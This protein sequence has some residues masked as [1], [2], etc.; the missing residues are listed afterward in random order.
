MRWSILGANSFSGNHFANFI[1]S[2][3]DK[4]QRIGRPKLDLNRN[5]ETICTLIE[6]FEADYV[7]NFISNSL[8]AA[9]WINPPEWFKTN[10]MNTVALIDRLRGLPLKRFVHVSTPEV[11]GSGTHRE[12]SGYA[13]TTPY[14]VSR[15][16]AEMQMVAHWKA[17]GFPVVMTRSANVYGEGQ[18]NKIIPLAMECK[19]RGTVLK[20]DGGG[21]SI[22]SFIHINDVCTATRLIAEKG[23][24]GEAYN[25]ATRSVISIRALVEKIGCKWEESPERMAKDHIYDLQTEKIRALGWTDTISLDEGLEE[26]CISKQSA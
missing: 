20:L 5:L 3:G 22:R 8:V 23:V 6:G 14:A 24:N 26:L 19:E 16:A 11:Y 15:A 7:V 2:S 25:I 13:P 21:K 18:T 12:D 4:V 9:S 17:Y 10:A 1:E